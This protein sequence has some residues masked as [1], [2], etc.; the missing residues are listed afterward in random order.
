MQYC[1]GGKMKLKVKRLSPKGLQKKLAK[2]SRKELASWVLVL[3]SL[4]NSQVKLLN[5]AQKALRKR[6]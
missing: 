2:L 3:L 6:R 5:K 1:I 4:I